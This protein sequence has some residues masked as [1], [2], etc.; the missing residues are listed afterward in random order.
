M[1]GNK[2]IIALAE[3]LMSEIESQGYNLSTGVGNEGQKSF[4]VHAYDDGDISVSGGIGDSGIELRFYDGE[5]LN[6]K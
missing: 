3:V 5:I 2:K 6:I 1:D 4:M